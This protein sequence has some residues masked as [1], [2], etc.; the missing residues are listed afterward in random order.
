ML[1]PSNLILIPL[2][3]WYTDML[4]GTIY[5]YVYE[6][7]TTQEEDTTLMKINSP[8]QICFLSLDI[9]SRTFSSYA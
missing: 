2:R 4:P 3:C 7:F 1:K 6:I 5:I 8:A 9:C